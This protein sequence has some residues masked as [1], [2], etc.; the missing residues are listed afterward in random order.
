MN[1]MGV[2]YHKIASILRRELACILIPAL[3]M[4]NFACMIGIQFIY[5][6]YHTEAYYKLGYPYQLQ[7][8]SNVGV[9]VLS[10]LCVQLVIRRL[11]KLCP[12]SLLSV[13]SI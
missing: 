12:H 10:F 2:G 3:L 1:A 11:Q 9:I 13:E 5:S 7:L 8:L 6:R 4:A